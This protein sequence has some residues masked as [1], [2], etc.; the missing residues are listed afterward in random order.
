M[1][2]HTCF[3][4]LVR[5][6]GNRQDGATEL[7]GPIIGNIHI[8]LEF[9]VWRYGCR[10]SKGIYIYILHKIFYLVYRSFNVSFSQEGTGVPYPPFSVSAT[11]LFC[12]LPAWPLVVGDVGRVY[13]GD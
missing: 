1:P 7:V 5:A 10:V 12:R 9:L 3:R 2:V 11:P 8:Y 6:K 4:L 13:A